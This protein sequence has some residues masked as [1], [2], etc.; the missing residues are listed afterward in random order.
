M[1]TYGEEVI[2]YPE[3]P[4]TKDL[5]DALKTAKFGSVFDQRRINVKPSCRGWEDAVEIAIKN[6][7]LKRF[8]KR[9]IIILIDFDKQGTRLSEVKQRIP[10]EC[11][12]KFYIVGWSGN[13]EE[14]KHQTDCAGKGVHKLAEKL[15]DDCQP[16]CHGLWERPEFAQMRESTS[17]SKSECERLRAELLPLILQTP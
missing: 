17:D 10:P 14:L 5:A 11:A 15:V 7:D 3:D 1:S 6:C 16:E 2:I 8:S 9:R 12:S 4:K 13:I